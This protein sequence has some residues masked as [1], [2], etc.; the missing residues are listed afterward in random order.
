MNAEKYSIRS[1]IYVKISSH[2][3]PGIESDKFRDIETRCDLQS[4]F[5][6]VVFCLNFILR[7]ML[8]L[9]K[10]LKITQREVRS[11]RTLL[12][13]AT[14]MKKSFIILTKKVFSMKHLLKVKEAKLLKCEAERNAFLEDMS[15]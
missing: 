9:V 14:G 10:R 5:L 4:L 11:L 13:N 8:D 6:Y 15:F 7:V 12:K 3:D 2:S 1:N